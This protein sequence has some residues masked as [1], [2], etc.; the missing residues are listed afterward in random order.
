MLDPRNDK[1][2]FEE[3]LQFSRD[4]PCMIAD[5]Q[6]FD[7]EFRCGFHRYDVKSGFRPETGNVSIAAHQFLHQS[8]SGSVRCVARMAGHWYELDADQFLQSK[9]RIFPRKGGYSDTHYLLVPGN[10]WRRFLHEHPNR[11]EHDHI[12]GAGLTAD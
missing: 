5:D 2:G 1:G 11:I 4:Y 9:P 8:E 3:E 6:G 7:G 12:A 10:Y